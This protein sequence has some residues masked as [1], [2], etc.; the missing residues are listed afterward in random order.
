MLSSTFIHLPNIGAKKEHALWQ[1]G[2]RTWDDY[3]RRFLAQR[4]LFATEN[5]DSI[6]AEIEAS[7]RALERADFDFFGAR[8]PQREH[9]R[10]ALTIPDRTVFLDIETTGLSFYYDE[11][12]LVGVSSSEGYYCFIKGSS[13]KRLF[14]ILSGAKCIVTF[15]GTMFD[16]KFL[17]KEF[18]RLPLPK[19]HV[20]LRFLGRSVGFSGGQKTVE[21][22]LGVER[23]KEICGMQGERAPML[24]H[25]YRLGDRGSARLLIEYNHA[26][27]EGMRVIFDRVADKVVSALGLSDNA[28]QLFSSRATEL[29]WA[30]SE[31][32]AS[33]N[34]IYIP[35]FRGK[36]GPQI[37]YRQLVVKGSTRPLRVVGIDLT[38]SAKRLTGWCVLEG[39]HARTAALGSDRVI[40]RHTMEAKPDLVSIDSPLSLPKGRTRVSDDDPGRRQFGI[41]R[42]CE[43]TLMQRGVK[44]YP[45]LIN[46]MQ[47]LTARGIRLARALRRSGIPVI[48]SYPGAAQDIM[49]IPRKRAGLEYLKKGL[50]DFGVRG[51]FLATKVTHDEVDAVT[52]A[53]VGLFFWSGRFEALGNE[54]EDYLIIPD[55]RRSSKRW[56]SRRVFG[57][58]GPIAAGKTTAAGLLRE[59]GFAY[60]R[61]SQVLAKLLQEVGKPV[62]RDT[63][64][65]IGERVHRSPGQRWLC[66]KLVSA[67]PS[68]IDLS[69]DGLRWP[70]DHATLTEAYG[71]SFCHVHI[72][73]SVENRRSR[74]VRDG[75]SGREFDAAIRHPV[76]KKVTELTKFAHLQIP[77]DGSRGGFTAK[78]NRAIMNKKNHREG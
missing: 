38:G 11:I 73:A 67:L 63:L 52:A 62:D 42:Q 44:V 55:L 33:A 17:K 69:I 51:D 50:A 20:D 71:P 77:N 16:L 6:A 41:L 32:D 29:N 59:R 60:G 49:G 25:E 68:D 18:D 65:T 37:T 15:N 39:N 53:I 19:S 30:E 12:T 70:E 35:P 58:S 54:S 26:D 10:V 56:L 24:W 5:S 8:L 40:L 43:R 61:F 31:P 74:Y 72:T 3:E 4:Q 78:V 22:A 64:Q 28:G 57:F 75:H 34:R 47:A 7:R 66:R 48:E 76:E 21:R 13:P 14:E 45:S 46:S 23:P 27:V 1:A 2:V 36:R 9:Y